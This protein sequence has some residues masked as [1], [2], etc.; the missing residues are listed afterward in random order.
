M[1]L[2]KPLK[3]AG[4]QNLA[5][6]VLPESSHFFHGKLIQLRDAVLRFAPT[7]LNQSFESNNDSRLK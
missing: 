3:W 1:E 2:A 5:V 6:I 4:E 7:V